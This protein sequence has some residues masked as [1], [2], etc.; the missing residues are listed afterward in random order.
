MFCTRGS[1]AP[2]R[3]LG[4][5][6]SPGN[7]LGRESLGSSSLG[8]SP[9][10]A[11][12]SGRDQGAFCAPMSFCAVTSSIFFLRSAALAGSLVALSSFLKI[13]V[14]ARA[15]DSASWSILPFSSALSVLVLSPFP[16]PSDSRASTV[17]F[18]FLAESST[19]LM[20]GSPHSLLFER[21]SEVPQ[22]PLGSTLGLVVTLSTGTSGTTLKA[23]TALR[24]WLLVTA[25]LFFAGLA[26]SGL[27]ICGM[28]HVLSP[29][30]WL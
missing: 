7:P 17:V 2:L 12:S 21:K 18:V 16:P 27:G 9:V 6:G 29:V 22:S 14:L 1:A 19:T 23:S 26:A 4:G 5:W 15:L 8:S 13:S 24:F 25:E 30:T 28:S 11:G 10:S 20:P 3:D